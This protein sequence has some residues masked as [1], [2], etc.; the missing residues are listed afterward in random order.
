MGAGGSRE[1]NDP[2]LSDKWTADGIQRQFHGSLNELD[3][4][5]FEAVADGDEQTTE[6]LL[7]EGA[8]VNHL[9]AL[10]TPL[11]IA[12]SKQHDETVAVLR[13]AG[14]TLKSAASQN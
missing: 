10:G 11:K 3:E 6:A 1:E 7:K 13:K 8:N 5:L 14:A 2:E 12:L 9:S 4:A